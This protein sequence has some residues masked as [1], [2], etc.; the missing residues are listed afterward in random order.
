[1]DYIKSDE[2]T[3]KSAAQSTGATAFIRKALDSI[4]EGQGVA[5]KDLAVELQTAH[6]NVKD[7]QQAYIRIGTV[8]SR[9][10]YKQSHTR[11][12]DGGGYTYVVRMTETEAEAVEFGL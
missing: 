3:E 12:M 5:M 4:P 10:G 1:M 6:G 11:K 7:R 9:K 2:L 8:L